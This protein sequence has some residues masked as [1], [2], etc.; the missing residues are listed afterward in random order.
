VGQVSLVGKTPNLT[1]PTSRYPTYLPDPTY[2]PYPTYLPL[3]V[4]R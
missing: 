3:S 2:L 4:T 1:Y